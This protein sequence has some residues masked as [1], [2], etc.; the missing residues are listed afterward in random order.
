MPLPPQTKPPSSKRK[1]KMAS[2]LAPLCESTGKP[3]QTGYADSFLDTLAPFE[4]IYVNDDAGELSKKKSRRSRTKANRHPHPKEMQGDA[5]MYDDET[6]EEPETEPVPCPPCPPQQIIRYAEPPR[7][8]ADD[9]Y[10]MFLYVFS[11]VLLLF[12]LEQ[13]LQIG[14]H[15]GRNTADRY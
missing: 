3:G 4:P 10:D 1:K 14:I 9:R 11:G 12:L 7:P 2:R 6:D 13:F 5:G 8:P 15:I